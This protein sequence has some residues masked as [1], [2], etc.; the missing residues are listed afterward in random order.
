MEKVSS[1]GNFIRGK[2]SSDESLSGEKFA[3]GKVSS[4]G[5]FIRG[6]T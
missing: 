2:V 4:D 1:D 5:N 3:R 6:K